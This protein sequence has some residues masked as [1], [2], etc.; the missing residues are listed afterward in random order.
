MRCIKLSKVGD[1]Y[2]TKEGYEIEVL[3]KVGNRKLKIKFPENIKIYAGRY[4]GDFVAG[5]VM[6]STN[7]VAHV[8]YMAVNEVV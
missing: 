8:Q 3:E 5:A 2:I 6:Y 7:I 4:K 1:K